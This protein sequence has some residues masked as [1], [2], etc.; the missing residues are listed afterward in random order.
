MLRSVLA[1]IRAE[2]R[3]SPKTETGGA[4]VGYLAREGTLVITNACGPGP[5]A[6]LGR[7][8]VMIDGQHAAAFCTR[9]YKDSGGR[10]DYV[11]DWHRHPAFSL[12]ASEQDIE[13]MLTIQKAGC[14]SVPYPVS[15]IYR[16]LPEKLAIYCLVK[17]QLEKMPLSWI[18][19]LPI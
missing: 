5:R 14:C 10:L 1:V 2:V 16:S 18:D 12:A 15:A 4:L 3:L 13:A 8:S 9:M 19:S 7:T 11:G 6:D 17:N